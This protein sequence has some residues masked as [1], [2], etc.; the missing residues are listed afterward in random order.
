MPGGRRQYFV[1]H[2]AYIGK[3][4]FQRANDLK[5]ET[6]DTVMDVSMSMTWESSF[7]CTRFLQWV[8]EFAME[9]H[10]LRWELFC[11]FCAKTFHSLVRFRGYA[12][13]YNAKAQKWENVMFPWTGK[14][15]YKLDREEVFIDFTLEPAEASFEL[16]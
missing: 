5:P 14:V 4:G 13:Q 15:R 16:F 10:L 2:A 1:L 3:K 8:Y 11:V 7:Y 9:M 12:L 6:I